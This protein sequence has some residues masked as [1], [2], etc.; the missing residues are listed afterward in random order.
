MG[1]ALLLPDSLTHAL[2]MEEKADPGVATR[3]P[4]DPEARPRDAHIARR[5]W[6]RGYKIAS[7]AHR[8][9]AVGG[10]AAE[11]CMAGTCPV[12]FTSQLQ[13]QPRL[14]AK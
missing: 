2:N 6:A 9:Y 10:W 3:P 7:S 8:A 12:G 11:D 5:R 1:G 14:H 4:A 13:M